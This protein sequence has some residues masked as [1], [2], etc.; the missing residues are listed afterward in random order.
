VQEAFWL[1]FGVHQRVIRGLMDVVGLSEIAAGVEPTHW[2]GEAAT[3]TGDL[4][5]DHCW[6]GA[7]TAG[8]FH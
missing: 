3:L 2:N 6:Q 5:H 8:S 4:A 7:S 1:V